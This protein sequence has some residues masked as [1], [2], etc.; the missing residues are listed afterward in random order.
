MS[1]RKIRKTVNECRC[2]LPDCPSKGAPWISKDEKIPERCRTC[3]RY[4]WNNVDRRKKKPA[5]KAVKREQ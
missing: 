5:K 3:L 1:V 2:E 4:T